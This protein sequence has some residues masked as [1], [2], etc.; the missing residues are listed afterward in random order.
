MSG[1]NLLQLAMDI[2]RGMEMLCWCNLLT[3]PST[4]MLDGYTHVA[5]SGRYS[6]LLI[7]A[8]ILLVFP[9]LT[10]PMWTLSRLSSLTTVTLWL[11]RSI[12]HLS[13][14]R[15]IVI[16]WRLKLRMHRVSSWLLL[17]LL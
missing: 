2:L 8:L 1:L 5:T 14:I 9:T 6:I 3:I 10:I 11:H 13:G 15:N 7:S 12:E 17:L 16:L 4:I